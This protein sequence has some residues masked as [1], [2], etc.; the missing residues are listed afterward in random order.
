MEESAVVAGSKRFSMFL[1]F[2]GVYTIHIVLLEYRDFPLSLFRRKI[3]ADY[4]V[5][6]V[7]SSLE[8]CARS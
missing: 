4:L 1:K 6:M 8:S 3:P 2:H 7:A 5:L